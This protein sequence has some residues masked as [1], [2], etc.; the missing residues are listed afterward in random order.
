MGDCP[1]AL[2]YGQ[3][4]L[5]VQVAGLGEDHPQVGLTCVPHLGLT[6]PPLSPPPAPL[7]PS[8]LP[9]ITFL[10]AQPVHLSSRHLAVFSFSCTRCTC[11]GVA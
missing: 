7:G 5:R 10:F 2:E 8:V 3:I 11:V 4:A 9:R 6:P 1:K